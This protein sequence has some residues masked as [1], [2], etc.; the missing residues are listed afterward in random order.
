MADAALGDDVLGEDPT[1]NC[2]QDMAAEKLGKEAAL[3]VSSGTL[4]NLIGILVSARSG[5]EIIADADSHVF[6][7]EAGGAATLGGIQ[8]MP[9][10]TEAGIM[11]PEQIAD[12]IRTDDQHH[13]R[14]AAVT[15]EN[16]HNRHGGV[17][18]PL[19]TLRAASDEAHRNGILVHL[20]GARIFNA[21]LATGADV[22]ELAACADTVTF[23]LSKGLAAPAGSVLLGPAQKIAEAKR[24]RK[25]LGGGMR[26]IG[27][28]GAAGIFALDNMVGRL[29]EDHAN[30]QTLAEGLASIGGITID[31]SRV[32]TNLVIFGLAKMPVTRFLDECRKRGL[33]GGAVGRTRVRFVTHYGINSEN[34]QHALE[35]VAGVLGAA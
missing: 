14:T 17:A 19:A 15:F 1:I 8:I 28:L 11:A 32:Q 22:K 27:M 10:R 34:V 20:D 2:L 35:V 21:A 4:G 18:W 29:A 6:L 24:W 30:A 25:M 16:T 13:P 9:V 5:Q 12:A 3:F 7:S 31:L 33:K 26:Q 23:C